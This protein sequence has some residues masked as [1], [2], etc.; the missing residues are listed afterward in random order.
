MHKEIVEI[1]MRR[2]N[3]SRK[4]AINKV[5]YC[6]HRLANEALPSGDY[7]LAE[8]ILAEELGLEMDYIYE[9]I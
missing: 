2:D 3:I 5:N 4:E 1:L 6:K 7:N 8:D 9:L